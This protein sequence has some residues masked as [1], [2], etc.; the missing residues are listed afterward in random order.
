MKLTAVK[1]IVLYY[2]KFNSPTAMS[3][4]SS[5]RIWRKNGIV[6]WDVSEMTRK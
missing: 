3:F 5:M 1:F 4:E 6:F 2:D